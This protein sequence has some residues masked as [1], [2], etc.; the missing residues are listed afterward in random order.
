MLIAHAEDWTSMKWP[1]VKYL[2]KRRWISVKTDCCRV[3]IGYGNGK[4]WAAMLACRLTMG[5]CCHVS[6]STD[7][8][9]ML[10]LKDVVYQDVMYLHTSRNLVSQLI[11]D[12]E[13]RHHLKETSTTGVCPRL[14][15]STS[16]GRP[17]EDA[18]SPSWPNRLIII[19]IKKIPV[20]C[21]NDGCPRLYAKTPHIPGTPPAL[22]GQTEPSSSFT[23][24]VG[25]T[26]LL[27]SS[28]SSESSLC[29]PSMR[30]V[31]SCMWKCLT[32]LRG[33]L[34]P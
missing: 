9:Y 32:P 2:A 5:T 7:Y 30:G 18:Y 13:L 25:Q 26:G 22:V 31:R 8:G 23:A 29:V 14:Y 21:L 16:R 34:P 20:C 10:P 24:L 33:H 27:S 6:V 3:P 11:N 17:W 1:S 19:N 4:Q 12:G 15:V 28:T